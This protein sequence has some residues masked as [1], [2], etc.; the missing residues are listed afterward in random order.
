MK[1]A[2]EVGGNAVGGL[3]QWGW[4]VLRRFEFE[5]RYGAVGDAAGDDVVEVAEIGGDVEGE[6]VG[7][8]GLGDVDAD[9]GDFLFA[10]GAAGE[11]P[12]AGEFA[13]ALGGDAE[14]FAGED[15]GFF[16]EADEVDGA[17]VRAAFAGEVAA[18]VEDGVADELAGAVVGDVAAAVDFV[19]FYGSAG[20]QV[21]GG[22][23]VGAGGVAAEGEDGWVF[24]EEERVADEVGFAGGYD[25]GLEAEAF[26]VGDAAELEEVDMHYRRTNAVGWA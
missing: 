11:G 24:E 16:H 17:E 21:V 1:D 20:E 13:D 2:A 15:E 5:G 12:D 10:D 23:D 22:Q 3:R 19:D 14:I 8:D 18:E 7:G 6:A 4:G 26:G 25:F 9:G